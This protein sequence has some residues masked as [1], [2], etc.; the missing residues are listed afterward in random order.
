MAKIGFD[1]YQHKSIAGDN[2][3]YEYAAYLPVFLSLVNSS[4][5]RKVS[6]FALLL[7]VWWRV[8]IAEKNPNSSLDN[9]L[10]GSFFELCVVFCKENWQRLLVI[11]VTNKC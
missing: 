7:I 5:S 4:F 1:F 10:K 2:I 6:E 9:V 8:Y 3:S 11:H